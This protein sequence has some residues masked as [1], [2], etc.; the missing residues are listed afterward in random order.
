M[1][2]RSESLFETFSIDVSE[3]TGFTRARLCGTLKAA[4]APDLTEALIDHAVGAGAKLAID[5]SDLQALD[6]AGLSVLIQLVTR[7]RMTGGR[8]VLVGPTSFVS[9][10]LE[11]TRLNTWFEICTSLAEAS[12][13]LTLE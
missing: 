12:R 13:K 8:V 7:S 1:V 10:V 9:G 6:S 11:V 5:L 3:Q 4:D 2:T